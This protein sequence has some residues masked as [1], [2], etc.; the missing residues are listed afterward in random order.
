[1]STCDVAYM[2]DGL[3]YASPSI[4]TCYCSHVQVL[5]PVPIYVSSCH[6]PSSAFWNFSQLTQNCCMLLFLSE[7][8]TL[9]YLTAQFH[10]SAAGLRSCWLD[11]LNW[12][13]F[14]AS[15]QGAWLRSNMHGPSSVLDVGGVI[16]FQ[17]SPLAGAFDPWHPRAFFFFFL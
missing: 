14:H 3:M 12:S 15:R 6:W 7:L 16:S 13:V 2:R 4:L 11:H 17:V 8:F 1:M 10:E 5:D 9:K